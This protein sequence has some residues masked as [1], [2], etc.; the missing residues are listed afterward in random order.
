MGPD[1]TPEHFRRVRALLKEPS[2]GC[3][4][5]RED[6]D[7]VGPNVLGHGEEGV[8]R[9][10]LRFIADELSQ[11]EEPRMH[12]MRRIAS[13]QLESWL[14]YLTKAATGLDLSFILS[15][16]HAPTHA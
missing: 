7:R 9:R 8:Q 16:D 4:S 12:Q 14:V 13:K 3:A 11:R 5:A 1:S 15:R 10:P 2:E 6:L